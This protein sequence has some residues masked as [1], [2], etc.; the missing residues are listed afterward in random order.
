M[1]PGVVADVDDGGQ[2][3]VAGGAG[4]VGKLTEAAAGCWTPRRKRAPPTPPTRTVT[5]TSTE[6][7]PSPANGPG[8]GSGREDT[9]K[10]STRRISVTRWYEFLF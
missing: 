4:P 1:H 8:R 7:R 3:V 10:Q 9:P 2:F 5:F 6:T